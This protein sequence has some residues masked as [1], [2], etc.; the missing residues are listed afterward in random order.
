MIASYRKPQVGRR[1]TSRWE[2]KRPNQLLEPRDRRRDA[3]GRDR[4]LA[5]GEGVP[6][7]RIPRGTAALQLTAVERPCEVLSTKYQSGSC[8]LL[9]ARAA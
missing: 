7:G 3:S 6:A 8:W 9:A 2:G 5:V 4:P 1:P